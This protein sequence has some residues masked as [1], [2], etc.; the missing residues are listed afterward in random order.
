MSDVDFTPPPHATEH[1]RHYSYRLPMTDPDSGPK[2]AAGCDLSA[3]G[4]TRACMPAP[5]TT[6][7]SREEYSDDE[8]RAWREYRDGGTVRLLAAMVAIPPMRA[9]ESVDVECPNCGGTLGA[10]RTVRRAYVECSTPH[11]V[12]F[13]AAL[14]PDVEFWP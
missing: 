11:C 13:E 4:S 3:P 7:A 1:C 8:R 10:A 12:K 6:C 5:A 14:K 2:C 9:R